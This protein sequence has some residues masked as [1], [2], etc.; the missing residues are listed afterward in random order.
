VGLMVWF[1]LANYEMQPPRVGLVFFLAL[2]ISVGGPALMALFWMR[3]HL[4]A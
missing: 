4:F 3:S 2:I 1:A